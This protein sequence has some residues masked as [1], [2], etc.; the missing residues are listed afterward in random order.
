M[1]VSLRNLVFF[2]LNHIVK[3]ITSMKTKRLVNQ[4][5]SLVFLGFVVVPVRV[6]SRIIISTVYLVLTL[7]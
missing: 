1:A 6:N 7:F 4:K 5:Y 3:T 2:L